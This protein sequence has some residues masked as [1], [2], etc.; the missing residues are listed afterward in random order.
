MEM[1]NLEWCAAQIVKKNGDM[2]KGEDLLERKLDGNDECW[3][4]RALKW[5]RHDWGVAVY[6]PTSRAV[7]QRTV[8]ER[9]GHEKGCHLDKGRLFSA[10]LVVVVKRMPSVPV[11]DRPGRHPPFKS[12]ATLPVHSAVAFVV[13]PDDSNALTTPFRHLPDH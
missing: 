10:S 1:L 4:A 3:R 5:Y 7:V 8:R 9:L 2:G 6:S 12:S 11:G 13:V